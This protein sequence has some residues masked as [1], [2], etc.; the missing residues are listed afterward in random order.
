MPLSLSLAA[1]KVEMLPQLAGSLS[2]Q[3]QFYSEPVCTVPQKQRESGNCR[4]GRQPIET[5]LNQIFLDEQSLFSASCATLPG[6]WP[7]TEHTSCWGTGLGQSWCHLSRMNAA[8]GGDHRARPSVS[9]QFPGLPEQ[10]RL[11]CW[12]L[13]RISLA[14][15]VPVKGS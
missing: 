10:S 3:Y 6:L 2:Q 1:L 14:K 4:L 7:G 9:P 11:I 15:A 13:N 8:K 12:S 5:P